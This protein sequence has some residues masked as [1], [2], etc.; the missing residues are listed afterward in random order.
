[1]QHLDACTGYEAAN[2]D[3][4]RLNI[5]QGYGLSCAAALVDVEPGNVVELLGR[6]LRGDHRADDVG[7]PALG[8]G[9]SNC[10]IRDVAT[11]ALE[12][13]RRNARTR[14]GTM[15]NDARI[16]VTVDRQRQRTRNRR[17]RHDK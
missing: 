13:D 15:A 5:V 4:L 10:P 12:C 6:I 14:H 3:R 11:A 16:K 1:M 8:Q 7:L 17:G 2:I 9:I